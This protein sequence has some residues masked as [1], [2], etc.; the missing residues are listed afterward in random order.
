[1]PSSSSKK[2]YALSGIGAPTARL[3]RPRAGGIPAERTASRIEPIT[4]H[5]VASKSTTS[6]QNRRTLK[7]SMNDSTLPVCRQAG[8]TMCAST[9][10]NGITK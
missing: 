5:Q 6:A 1:M 10:K 3:S 9:W 8:A 2:R 7:R 4:N